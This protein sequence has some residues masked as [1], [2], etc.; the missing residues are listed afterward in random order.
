VFDFVA[1]QDRVGKPTASD[2]R[3]GLITLPTIC[4][5]ESNPEDEALSELMSTGSLDE[6]SLD[7]LI[8]SINASGA[9]EQA[10]A[11][12]REHTQTAIA[13]LS[14]FSNSVEREGLIDLA[15]FVTNRNA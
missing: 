13:K 1:D 14:P 10:L 7:R 15:E 8:E 6:D 4:Y 9:I 2:L 5:L 3:Q 11:E 12:A